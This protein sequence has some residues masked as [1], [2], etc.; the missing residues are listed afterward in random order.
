MRTLYLFLSLTLFSQVWTQT[1]QSYDRAVAMESVPPALHKM[2][3]HSGLNDSLD[4]FV[5]QLNPFFLWGDFDNDGKQDFTL[6]VN[7]KKSSKNGRI[8]VLFGNGNHSFLDR[9]SLL[10]YPTIT[11]W[12]VLPR[13]TEVIRVLPDDPAPPILKGDGIVIS[14]VETSNSLVYWNGKRFVSYTSL[15]E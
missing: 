5:G 7:P 9:D 13:D 3:A 14:K 6:R 12:F 8:V 11:A 10:T 2:M 15:G 1:T 4:I